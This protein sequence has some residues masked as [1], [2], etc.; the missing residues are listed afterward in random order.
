MQNRAR[1]REEKERSQF[2]A[3]CQRCEREKLE[4]AAADALNAASRREGMRVA[5]DEA[6]M[7]LRLARAQV[8]NDS[9]KKDLNG[10]HNRVTNP[11]R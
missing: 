11:F 2:E 7:Q 6:C 10:Q 8:N 1:E 9:K 4:R 3:A 5:S